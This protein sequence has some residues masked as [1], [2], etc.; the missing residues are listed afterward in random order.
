MRLATERVNASN[1]KELERKAEVERAKARDELEWK[2]AT[3]QGVKDGEV[4]VEEDVK[5]EEQR[6]SVTALASL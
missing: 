2:E 4:K 5:E 6:V 3:A 1:A